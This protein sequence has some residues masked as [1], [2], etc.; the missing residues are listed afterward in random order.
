MRSAYV[1]MVLLA[2]SVVL[3]GHP[4]GLTRGVDLGQESR[5]ATLVFDHERVRIFETNSAVLARR[6][7]PAAVIVAIEDGPTTRVGDATWSDDA[8]AIDSER[9]IIVEPRADASTGP[10]PESSADAG[11]QPGEA[12][13]VGMSFRPIFENDRVEVLRARMEVDAR[14]GVHTH[15]SDTIVVHLSG[16]AIEDTANGVTKVNRWHPGDVEFEGRGSSHSARNVGPAVDVVLV[17]LRTG[18]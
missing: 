12:P 11:S 18:G 14:E 16:G 5:R 4:I 3:I 6:D 8:A 17:T 2:G 13:F 10:P 9:L 1:V 7:H 15:G